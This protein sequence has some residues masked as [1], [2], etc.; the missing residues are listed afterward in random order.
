LA[1]P[2]FHPV[3]ALPPEL[4]RRKSATQVRA[5]KSV[6]DIIAAAAK[7]I[8][9]VGVDD[10][11]TNTLAERAGVLVRTVYRYFPNKFAIVAHLSQQ[12][13][14]AWFEQMNDHL[15]LIGSADSDW[16][17]AFKRLV[18][19]WIDNVNSQP[20]GLAVVQAMGSSPIL[21]D[22]DKEQFGRIAGALFDNISPHTKLDHH[23]LRVICHTVTSMMYGF[24]DSYARIP[25]T[26][27]TDVGQMTSEMII[28]VVE[29]AFFALDED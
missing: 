10:L 27:R 1:V 29:P 8:E 18:G 20:G 6:Q 15:A 28:K 21:R 13:T 25:S 14:D 17:D 2:P 3:D 4:R 22:L 23:R 24:G 11:N 26:L 12:M 5:Q 7:L 16:R 9:E 19:D